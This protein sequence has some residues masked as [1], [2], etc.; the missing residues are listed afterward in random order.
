MNC[1]V[2]EL[3]RVQ[4]RR[5]SFKLA[6][7]FVEMVIKDVQRRNVVFTGS[8]GRA[9]LCSWRGVVTISWSTIHQCSCFVAEVCKPGWSYFG[10]NCYS[11]SN[12]CKT[13]AEAQKVC[14][15]YHANLVRIRNQE[16]NVYVQHRLN[17]AKGWIGLN[18]LTT[19]GTFE[20]ADNQPVNFTYWAE[21]QPNNFRNEDCVH[22]LGVRHGFL[23]NDVD[24]NSCRNYTCSEG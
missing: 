19:E 3:L 16:E 17:G 11:T 20:W 1:Q 4:L 7:S 22:T 12:I 9:W 13:W 6:L 14:N 15:S 21:N 10:G 18:D 24:C 23:W 2:F 8:F 5:N